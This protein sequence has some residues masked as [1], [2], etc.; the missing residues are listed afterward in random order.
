[1][2][3]RFGSGLQAS[4]LQA[5]LKMKAAPAVQEAALKQLLCSMKAASMLLPSAAVSAGQPLGPSSVNKELRSA[6]NRV[7]TGQMTL[8]IKVQVTYFQ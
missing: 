8:K 6:K 1:M 2:A 3:K 7:K 5:A 4:G